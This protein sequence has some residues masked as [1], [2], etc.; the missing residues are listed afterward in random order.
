MSLETVDQSGQFLMLGLADEVFALDATTIREILDPV[1]VAE[2]PGAAGFLRGVINV[3]GKIVPMA[4][5]RVRF[6]MQP[7]PITPDTRFVVLEITLQ[8]DPTIVAIVA[9]RVH[10]VTEL[11][12]STL[13][14]APSVGMQWQPEF[15]N[16]IGKWKDDFIIVPNIERIFN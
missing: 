2:V 1:P 3:R 13:E 8:G 15:V 6:G 9:D 4:D 5:L 12:L 7:T 10:E 11:P 14:K 16:G